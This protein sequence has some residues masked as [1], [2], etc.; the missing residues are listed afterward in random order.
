MVDP[1]SPRCAE[2]VLDDEWESNPVQSDL[3]QLVGDHIMYIYI[4]MYGRWNNVP[5]L[6]KYVYS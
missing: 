1:C 6:D 5:L 4:Y 3:S 2:A